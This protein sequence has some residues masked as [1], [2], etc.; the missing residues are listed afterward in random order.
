MNHRNAPPKPVPDYPPPERNDEQGAPSLRKIAVAL[1]I[2][3][4]GV[5]LACAVFWLMP[6]V[7]YKV[8]GLGSEHDYHRGLGLAVDITCLLHSIGFLAATIFIVLAIT[9]PADTETKK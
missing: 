1:I 2:G 5:T 7:Q 4:V 3:F 9:V 8:L 6:V